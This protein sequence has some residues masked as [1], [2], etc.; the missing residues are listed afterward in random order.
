MQIGDLVRCTMVKGQ[1]VGLVVYRHD[2]RRLVNVWLS[3]RGTS[4]TA[5][6]QIKQLEVVNASR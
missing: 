4:L 1:P 3:V 6:F 5:A 2:S